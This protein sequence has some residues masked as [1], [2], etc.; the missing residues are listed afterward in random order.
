MI[1]TGCLEP[2]I[3]KQNYDLVSLIISEFMSSILT[4]RLIN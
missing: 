2:D 3:A 4:E 1:L